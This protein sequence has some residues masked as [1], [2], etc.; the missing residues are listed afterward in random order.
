MIFIEHRKKISLAALCI[1]IFI[2]MMDIT[3]V[4]VALP[5]I[6]KDLSATLSDLQWIVDSYTLTFACFLISAGFLSDRLGAKN[7]FILGLSLFILT[8][9]GCAI[10]QD[11]K[12]LI[13]FRFFQGISA[14][15]VIPTSLSLTK[16]SFQ[17]KHEQL[18]AITIYGIV[19]STSS[20]LGL[21]LGSLLTTY[22]GWQSIFIINVPIGLISIFLSIPYLVESPAIFSKSSFDVAGQFSIIISVSALAFSL[23]EVGKY[24]WF[25]LPIVTSFCLFVISLAIFIAVEKRTAVP[26]LPLNIFQS[27]ILFVSIITGM[28]LNFGF[29]GC[30]FILPLYFQGVKKYSVLMTGLA[31]LPQLAVTP[32]AYYMGGNIIRIIGAKLPILIGLLIGS[33][34]FLSLVF[35][36]L[37]VKADLTYW[38]FCLP[39]I[40]IGF[41]RSFALPALTFE[42]M[43]SV[44]MRQTGIVSGALYASRQIGTL[45]GVAIFGTLLSFIKP[46]TSAMWVM[47]LGGSLVYLAA[48]ILTLLK[49]PKNK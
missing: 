37:F 46:F 20:V 34:G 28:I 47:F 5:T 39:L 14:A 13:F 42:G 15:L 29:Y 45:L 9:I 23:I 1:G 35:V 31:V 43:D 17:L 22:F 8:S 27:P 49:I 6:Q 40:G 19:G 3:V 7:I 4:N 41:G 36:L 25:S 44:P 11:S 10:A 24:G 21:P 32:I 2:V 12:L 26:M 48:Y 18:K 33:A 16:S 30:L 38:Y